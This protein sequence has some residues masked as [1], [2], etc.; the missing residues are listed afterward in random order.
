MMSYRHGIGQIVGVCLIVKQCERG[1]T[2]DLE[3][4]WIEAYIKVHEG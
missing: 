2:I 3:K 1:W 4:E